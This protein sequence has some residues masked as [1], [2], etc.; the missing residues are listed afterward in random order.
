M[1]DAE[2]EPVVATCHCGAVEL[3]LPRPRRV[4][5][6]NCS[7]CRR[8][9]VLWAYP[10]A[11]EVAV[12]PDPPP[13]RTYAWNGRNVDFHHCRTCGCVTHWTP[14]RPGRERMGV[15]ARLLPPEVLAAAEIERRDAAGTGIFA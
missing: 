1:S 12:R 15:N 14:R 11:A 5:H 13:T 3:R 7:L 8:Y 6:C 9:G 4:R 10:L 2:A